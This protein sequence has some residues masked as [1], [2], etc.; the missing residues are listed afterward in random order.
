MNI[1]YYKIGTR[2]AQR[3]KELHMTQ[4]QL[5][6]KIDM[7]KNY[8]SSIEN[9]SSYSLETFLMICDALDVTPDYILFGAIR[10]SDYE[11]L[12]DIIKM[13]NDDDLHILKTVAKAL[14]ESRKNG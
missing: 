9:G 7:S 12:I 10:N 3:R 5:A 6:E 11:N 13:C 1:D 4:N 2:I 8:I 14:I